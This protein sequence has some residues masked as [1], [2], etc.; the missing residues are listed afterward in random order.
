MERELLTTAET[1]SAAQ[2]GTMYTV[3][4][5]NY[6]YVVRVEYEPTSHQLK[7]HIQ[8]GDFAWSSDWLACENLLP[9]TDMGTHIPAALRL[10][11][12]L[13]F[14]PSSGQKNGWTPLELITETLSCLDWCLA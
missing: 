1:E 14:S 5:R 3:D 8:N 9:T 11:Q 12:L 13:T 2:V 4:L 10:L 6:K 7:L